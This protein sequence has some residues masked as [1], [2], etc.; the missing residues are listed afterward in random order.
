[1]RKAWY[2]KKEGWYRVG[3]IDREPIPEEMAREWEKK[4]SEYMAEKERYEKEKAMYSEKIKEW[5]S[6]I[7][8][9]SHYFVHL[10]GDEQ[11]RGIVV[12]DGF[13]FIWDIEEGGEWVLIPLTYIPKTVRG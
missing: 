10:H 7:V 3:E 12:Q 1:M 13:P 11:H 5:E 8:N 9:I 4:F 2:A 6:D